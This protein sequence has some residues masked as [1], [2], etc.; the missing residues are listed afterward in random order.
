L[1]TR[2]EAAVVSAFEFRC[3]HK[4]STKDELEEFFILSDLTIEPA[5]EA[6]ASVTK[7][8]LCE[9]RALA[10][11]HRDYVGKKQKRIRICAIAVEKVGERRLIIYCHVELNT[12]VRLRTERSLNISGNNCRAGRTACHFL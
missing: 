1:A 11:R 8:A 3:D 4:R 9:M 10:G 6:S 12:P 2:W 7:N 5:K